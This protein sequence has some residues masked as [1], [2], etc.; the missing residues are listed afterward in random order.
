M[1]C[2]PIIAACGVTGPSSDDLALLDQRCEAPRPEVCTQEYVPVCGLVDK[3][4]PC[5]TLPCPT[6]TWKTYSNACT[7][8]AIPY[9]VGYRAG[10][11]DAA[12][13]D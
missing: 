10:A 6:E 12:A 5:V 13:R 8:C 9:V 11:C 1:L 3:G 7:A 4:I 2:L